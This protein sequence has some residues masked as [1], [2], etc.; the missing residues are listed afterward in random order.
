MNFYHKVADMIE[1]LSAQLEQTENKLAE[2]LSHAT[3]GRFSKSDYGIDDMRRFV[4]DY[5]QSICSQ[6]EDIKRVTR[7]RDAAVA[8]LREADLVDC[9]HCKHYASSMIPCQCDCDN[10][11]LD[12]V[13][14]TCSRNSNW[15]WRGVE[16]EG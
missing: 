6:C 13:C 9:A 1:F 15:Q 14:K 16:V 3:G 2:L 5:N 10:C 4:D 7:E 8:D 12:C 11:R